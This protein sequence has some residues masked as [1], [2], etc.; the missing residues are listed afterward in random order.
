MLDSR[1]TEG[2]SPLK[3]A[4]FSGHADSVKMMLDYG[5][6]PKVLHNGGVFHILEIAKHFGIC[7][8]K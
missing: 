8:G 1:T 6:Y 5:A 2:V 7:K 3:A 4:A